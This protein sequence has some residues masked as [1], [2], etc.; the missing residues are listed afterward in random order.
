MA[1]A[2]MQR[3]TY[4]T[5]AEAIARA[6]EL[7][8]GIRERVPLADG[9][10]RL[11]DETVRELHDSGLFLLLVPRSMGG[12]ELN[13]DAVLDVTIA[14]GEACPSTGWVYSLLTAHMWLLA[15]FPEYIQRK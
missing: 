3:P 4:A 11:P 12:S 10:R 6:R 5:A 9:G 15:E 14:L 8:P 1:Q 13:Y 2:L 7:A